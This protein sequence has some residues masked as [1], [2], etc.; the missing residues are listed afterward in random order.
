MN[1]K[2][3]SI[4]A[5]IAASLLGAASAYVALDL[6]MPATVQRVAQVEKYSEDTREIILLD[7]LFMRQEE[8]DR[9]QR[10]LDR[11]PDNEELQKRVYDLRRQIQLLER[12]LDDL[13]D[14]DHES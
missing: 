5:G 10:A 7:K 12:Q 9:A 8:L 14:H 6:P 13:E 1:W 3:M 2:H 4:A 11:D